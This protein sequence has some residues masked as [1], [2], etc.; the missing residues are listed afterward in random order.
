MIKHG[1]WR[2]EAALEIADRFV[3]GAQ[4]R[5]A[6]LNLVLPCIEVVSSR[7]QARGNTEKYLETYAIA[8]ALCVAAGL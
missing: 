6:W 8:Q 3:V 5:D 1:L 4:E 7:E 2:T